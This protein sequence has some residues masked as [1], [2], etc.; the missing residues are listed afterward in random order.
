MPSGV[1]LYLMA[2]G[3]LA[4]F[5]AIFCLGMASIREYRNADPFAEPFGDVG[6]GIEDFEA[7]TDRIARGNV[8]KAGDGFRT[9]VLH[10]QVSSRLL[11]GGS[12]G[13]V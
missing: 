2:A 1:V 11:S 7:A 9:Q 8:A 3:A 12:E 10:R 13:A 5:G 6:A 4:S